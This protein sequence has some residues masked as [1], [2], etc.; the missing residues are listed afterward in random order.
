MTLNKALLRRQPKLCDICLLIFRPLV[1]FKFISFYLMIVL[2][3]F[4][5]FDLGLSVF[6]L[7]F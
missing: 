1:S 6:S 2:I 5:L 4:C 7:K 3:G